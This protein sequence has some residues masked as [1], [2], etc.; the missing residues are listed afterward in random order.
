LAF[1]SCLYSG[2]YVFAQTDQTSAQLQAANT[3]AGQAFNAVSAA[4]K[5]GANVT[6]LQNQ[7]SGAIDLLAQAENAYRSGDNNLAI[8][9]ANAVIPI[10]RQVTVAAQEAHAKAVTPDET[11]LLLTISITIVAAVVF[12]LVL[13]LLWRWFKRSYLQNIYKTK[14]KVNER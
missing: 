10:A 8:S 12:V 4:E 14:P 11:T 7:L 3:A 2:H 1:C 5:A 9:S 6:S 13:F